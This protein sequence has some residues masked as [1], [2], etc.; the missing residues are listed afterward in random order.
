M[1]RHLYPLAAML[2]LAISPGL[3]AQE[4]GTAGDKPNPYKVWEASVPG[5]TYTVRLGSMSTVTISEYISNSTTRVYEVNIAASGSALARFYY[6]EPVTDKSP[7][8]VGQVVIDRV[9]QISEEGGKRT[10]LS[11][12]YK[13]VV[14]DYPNTTHQHTIE[15]RLASLKEL[16]A[17]HSSARKA[18]LTGKGTSF[19]IEQGE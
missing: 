3:S 17:L 13:K 15:F 10:G 6:L 18:F 7:L 19:S 8:N 11:D 1:K 12:V 9:Q 14:K 16:Q 4:V 2:F 5:G